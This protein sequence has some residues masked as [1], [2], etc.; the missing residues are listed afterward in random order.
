MRILYFTKNYTTHDRRFLAKIRERHEVFFLQLENDGETYEQRPVPSGVEVVSWAGIERSADPEAWLRLMPAFEQVIQNVRPHLIQAGPIQSC[1]FMTALS[2]FHPFVMMSWGYDVLVDS[3][4]DDFWRW[5]TRF[6]IQRADRLVCDCR[7]VS[8]RIRELAG[9]EEQ[10]IV[11]FPWGVELTQFDDGERTK[12]LNEPSFVVIS[13]RTWREDYG[14]S[15]LLDAFRLAYQREPRLK[16]VLLGGG[17]M[18][19]TIQDYLTQHRLGE[20]VRLV[21]LRP[22]EELPEWLR[23]ADLYLSTA[24]S[25][26]SSISLLG[27][28]AAG[29]PVV[30]SDNPSNR[31]WVRD[32]ACGWLANPGDPRSFAAALV[33][34]VR[35]TP[36][37]RQKMG[38]TNRDIAVKRANWDENFALL[39]NVYEQL[40]AGAPG[41]RFRPKE[42]E[43][44]GAAI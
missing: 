30:V 20:A 9:C 16:L 29:L 39:L 15:V 6:T 11:E 37:Q 36:E 28:L 21:G 34:A 5:L 32:N 38:R 42:R 25:D 35:T 23:S 14:T 40:L 3:Q 19:G 10:K 27:A 18:S 31:E 26:G 43:L 2:G 44:L 24:P 13:T 4:R 7:H 17:P 1:G 12:P 33:E 8:A 22:E 41:E